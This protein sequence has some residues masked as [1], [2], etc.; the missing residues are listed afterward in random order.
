MRSMA[1]SSA[2]G[3]AM[4]RDGKGLAQRQ[5]LEQHFDDRA[6]IAADMAAVGQDLP[7]DFGDQPRRSRI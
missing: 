3:G 7:L 4:L 2:G 1:L 5:Q 6:G